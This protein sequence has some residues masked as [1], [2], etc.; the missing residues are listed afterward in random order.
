[1][2]LLVAALWLPIVVAAQS[3]PDVGPLDSGRTIASTDTVIA[4]GMRVTLVR[5][6]ASPKALVYVVVG[7]PGAAHVGC[8]LSTIL[9]NAFQGRF[10]DSVAHMG[11]ALSATSRPE[12][13]VVTLDVLSQFAPVAA[14]VLG[15]II[16]NPNL[17]AASLRNASS[18]SL[19]TSAAAAFHATRFPGGQFGSACVST[20]SITHYTAADLAL[21]FHDNVAAPST[22]VIVVGRFE[23][24]AVVQAITKAFGDWTTPSSTGSADAQPAGPPGLAIVHRPGAKQVALMVGAD[25]P[26]AADSDFAR[27]EV[28]NTVL[29]DGVT[30]RITRNVREIHG[31]AYAPASVLVTAPSG[32]AYWAEL[33]DVA[34]DVAYP[35][36]REIIAEISRLGASPPDRAEVE[37]AER[38]MIGRALF[39]TSTR[40]GVAESVGRPGLHGVLTT[41]GSDVERVASTYLAPKRLTIVVVGDTLALGAQLS[42]IR[43]ASESSWR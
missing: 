35:A 1:V 34:A 13:I 30:S 29:G 3:R 2:R 4:N 39:Q 32:A 11:G 41:S 33:A 26:G 19:D 17:E 12:R 31:Y 22:H 7:L 18:L 37:G 21:F 28:M 5:Y 27:L 40:L 38:Y 23:T 14:T 24:H 16:R 9:A 6:G 42:Q 25:T 8:G 15:E 43:Q 20:D 36:L 10:I